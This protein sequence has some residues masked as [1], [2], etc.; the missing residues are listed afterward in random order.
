MFPSPSSSSGR[1]TERNVFPRLKENYI[2]QNIAHTYSL[3]GSKIEFF[4]RNVI[5]ALQCSGTGQV[6]TLGIA[7]CRV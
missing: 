1:K 2:F 4:E 6:R 7:F 3:L 5:E